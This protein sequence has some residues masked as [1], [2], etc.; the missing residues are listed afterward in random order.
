LLSQRALFQGIQENIIQRATL[1][2]EAGGR[3]FE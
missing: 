2:I 1:C 3:N